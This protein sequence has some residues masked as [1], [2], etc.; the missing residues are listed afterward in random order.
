MI[1]KMNEFQVPKNF[2]HHIETV[3]TPPINSIFRPL[4]SIIGEKVEKR[5]DSLE[6]LVII[7]KP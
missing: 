3:D 5:L 6:Q 4:N 7:Q 1:F 2:N